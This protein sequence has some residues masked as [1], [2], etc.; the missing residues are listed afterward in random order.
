MP[1][2]AK[3][4]DTGTASRPAADGSHEIESAVNNHTSH[5]QWSRSLSQPY[6][7]HRS[8]SERVGWCDSASGSAVSI[9]RRARTKLR[10]TR[11]ARAHPLPTTTAGIPQSIQRQTVPPCLAADHPI[12]RHARYKVER[13]GLIFSTNQSLERTLIALYSQPYLFGVRRWLHEKN[14]RRHLPKGASWSSTDTTAWSTQK[15]P[16]PNILGERTTDAFDFR[17]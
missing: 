13:S 8:S 3:S 11:N 7:S 16:V 9:P 2:R 4:V 1:Y 12:P 14:R 6:R 5:H 17:Q 15:S 10:D